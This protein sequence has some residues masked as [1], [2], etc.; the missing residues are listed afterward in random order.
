MSVLLHESG[1]EDWTYDTI[2]FSRI[3]M[4]K[5]RY[6][7]DW[8]KEACVTYNHGLLLQIYKDSKAGQNNDLDSN[9]AL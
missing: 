6:G 1:T 8:V 9:T 7:S 2:Y 3:T 4:A 5:G